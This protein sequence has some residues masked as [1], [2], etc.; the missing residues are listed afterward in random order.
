[1]DA[2][3]LIEV[4]MRDYAKLDELILAALSDKPR[5]FGTIFGGEIYSACV[6]H[7]KEEPARVLDR[8]LQA[9]RKKG[10]IVFMKGWR[11][12]SGS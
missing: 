1:M 11:K 8:R 4:R 6:N 12:V 7:S 2:A 10:L 5:Q 3:E 9:L